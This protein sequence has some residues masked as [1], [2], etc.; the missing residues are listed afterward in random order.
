MARLES[1][2][3]GNGSDVLIDGEDDE[4]GHAPATASKRKIGGTNWV[5]FVIRYRN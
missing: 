5:R 2:I 3:G 1:M 4:L